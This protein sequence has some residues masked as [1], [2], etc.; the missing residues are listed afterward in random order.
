MANN[1]LYGQP[2]MLNNKKSLYSVLPGIRPSRWDKLGSTP[3]HILAA[4]NWKTSFYKCHPIHPSLQRRTEKRTREE[5]PRSEGEKRRWANMIKV[6]HNN[7][8]PLPGTEPPPLPPSRPRQLPIP[9][10]NPLRHMVAEAARQSAEHHG[11]VLQ[12]MGIVDVPVHHGVAS[13]EEERMELAEGTGPRQKRR[14]DRLLGVS[15]SSIGAQMDKSGMDAQRSAL[16]H[17]AKSIDTIHF[18]DRL[19]SQ[20]MHGLVLIAFDNVKH[21]PSEFGPLFH[22]SALVP[23]LTILGANAADTRTI[24]RKACDQ[25]LDLQGRTKPA[26][27]V[28]TIYFKEGQKLATTVSARNKLQL[29]EHPARNTATNVVV[30]RNNI[31]PSARANAGGSPSYTGETPASALVGDAV[32]E[33]DQDDDEHGVPVVSR[34]E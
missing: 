29:T 7:H 19:A 1:D 33:G 17:T 14:F 3:S 10:R 25:L 5:G 2:T 15:P 9:P 31:T 13:N 21:R 24:L 22:T 12:E 20:P 32:V 16:L 34:T 11:D 26:C 23:R 28:E 8:P 18:P 6:L 4:D 30:Q 27:K